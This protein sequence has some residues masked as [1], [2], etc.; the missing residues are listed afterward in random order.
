MR[1]KIY[2]K[3]KLSNDVSSSSST[4]PFCEMLFRNMESN[5]YERGLERTNY[6]IVCLS[7]GLADMV[8]L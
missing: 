5:I 7:Q 4:L 2:L 6:Q 8:L 1:T 3:V